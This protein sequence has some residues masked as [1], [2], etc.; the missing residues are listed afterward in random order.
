MKSTKVI[1]SAC[2]GVCLLQRLSTHISFVDIC[3]VPFIF[4]LLFHSSNEQKRLHFVRFLSRCFIFHFFVNTIA[5]IK[6]S[7]LFPANRKRI[8]VRFLHDTENKDLQSNSN[9]VF[10]SLLHSL[11]RRHRVFLANV[12]KWHD[13]QRVETAATEKNKIRKFF[14]FELHFRL[15]QLNNISKED[16]T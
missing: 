2:A 3:C 13:S 6:I 15:Q 11:L 8:F 12:D 10:L 16:C 1:I 4:C 14:A 9:Y 5:R 7:N